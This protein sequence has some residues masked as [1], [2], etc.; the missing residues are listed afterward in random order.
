M[1]ELLVINAA[2][3]RQDIERAI[4]ILRE[5]QRRCVIPSTAEE[6]GETIDVLIERWITKRSA[7]TAETDRA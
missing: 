1:P 7:E 4:G 5:K 6:I 3:S 2:S